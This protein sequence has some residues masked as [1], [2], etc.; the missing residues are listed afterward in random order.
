MFKKITFALL[1]T[2]TVTFQNCKTPDEDDP[3]PL[4]ITAPVVTFPSAVKN[5]DGVLAAIITVTKDNGTELKV[6]SAYAAFYKSKNPANKVEAGTVTINLKSTTKSDDNAYFYAASSGEP[7]GLVYQS[8]VFWKATG[9]TTNDVPS[10]NDNDGSGLPNV[11]TV[12][13]FI[14]MNA[15]QDKLISWTSSF[16]ADS[17]VFILKGTSGTYSKVFNNTVTSHTIPMAEIAKVG[18]GSATLQIIN[19]KL[20]IR[21][22]GTKNYAFLKQCIGICSK[23]GITP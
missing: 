11:P 20:Q 22:V 1:I 15:S 6:G 23:I 7:N 5:V 21:A 14:N 12:P 18:M 8:Q 10:I 2:G 17:V 19:Y 13:E 9:S 3:A 16:G 4:P